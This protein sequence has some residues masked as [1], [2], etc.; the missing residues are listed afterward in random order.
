MLISDQ[1]TNGLTFMRI[2]FDVSEIPQHLIKYLDLFC[3]IFPTLGSKTMPSKLVNSM[4]EKCLFDVSMSPHIFMDPENHGSIKKHIIFQFAYIDR[5][6]EK[7]FNLIT[8][9]LADPDLFDLE[10]IST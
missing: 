6:I 10:K 9:V 8:E 5:N 7:A 1:E 2:K 3:E 4:T